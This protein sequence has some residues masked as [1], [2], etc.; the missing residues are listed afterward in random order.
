MIFILTGAGLSAE[1]GLGTFRDEGG[2]WT[3]YDLSEVAT[4][5]GYARDPVKVL[6]FYD[7]R[8]ANAAGAEP[9]AAHR[10]L[11]RLSQEAGA[12][13]VT[14][15]V[16]T[17]LEAAG[18]KGVVHMHGQ[19][20]RALCNKCR[21]RWKAPERMCPFDAC[22]HCGAQ[23]VRPDVV[24]FGEMPYAMDEIE[25]GLARADLFVAVGTSGTV[26][27]AAGLAEAARAAGVDTLEI[28]L[29]PTGGAFDRGIYG[30]ASQV[31]PE[32]VDGLLIEA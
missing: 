13:L 12:M 20:D 15:N 25:D 18:A 10:A 14:Q 30:P 9:N 27:P 21:R 32:W 19:L 2:L 23:A 1:S 6:E 24:W 31:V 16:D 3:R 5:E 4:P 26:Y 11:A 29:E 22:P 7:A 28:N 8:R 17:L